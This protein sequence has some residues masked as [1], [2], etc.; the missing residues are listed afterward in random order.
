MKNLNLFTKK[1]FAIA[2]TIASLSMTGTVQAHHND[3]YLP[4]VP[5][6]IY[7]VLARPHHEHRQTYQRRDH[8][9]NRRRHSHS[10]NG[11]SQKRLIKRNHRH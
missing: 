7:N 6:I 10:H 9:D 3:D 1:T 4:L 5:F 2:L 11:Y 8:Y